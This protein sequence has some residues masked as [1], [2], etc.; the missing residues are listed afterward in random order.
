MSDAPDRSAS[1]SPWIYHARIHWQQTTSHPNVAQRYRADINDKVFP[2]DP[3]T[4]ECHTLLVDK[5][6]D[7]VCCYHD[8]NHHPILVGR[9]G[10][11]TTSGWRLYKVKLSRVYIIQSESFEMNTSYDVCKT[12]LFRPDALNHHQLNHK[13]EKHIFYYPASIMISG[14]TSSG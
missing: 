12:T 1:E 8:Q 10:Q 5:Y 13:I 4:M 2:R 7:A 14:C 11:L 3:Y 9:S 6:T